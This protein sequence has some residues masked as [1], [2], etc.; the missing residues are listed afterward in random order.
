MIGTYSQKVRG[1]LIEETSRKAKGQMA[2]SGSKKY[3]DHGDDG[4]T[5]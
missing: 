3:G 2:D 4:G 1:G 5:C